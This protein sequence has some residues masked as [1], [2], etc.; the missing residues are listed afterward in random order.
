[1]VICG[2]GGNPAD[3]GITRHSHRFAPRAGFAY[4]LTES[5]VIRAGYGLTNDPTNYGASLGNRQNYPDILATAISA[6]NSFSYATTLPL[7]LPAAVQ[8]DF[9]SG[10]VA[11]PLTAGVFTL[12]NRNYVRGYVQSWNFTV[13]QRING[14]TASAGYVASRAVDP[15]AALN[16][17]WS[18]IGTGT[19]GQ[20]LS[21][22]AKRTAITNTVGI[23]GTNKYDSVQA[24]IQHSFAHGFQFNVNYTFAKAEAYST[25]VAIPAYYRLNYGATGNIAHHTVGLAGFVGSPFG[26]GKQRFGSGPEAA[27]L[28]G[29]Q[30]NATGILR[31][32]T[33][34]TATASNTTLNAVGSSQFA[35][36]VSPPHQLGDIYQWYDKTAFAAP[37]TGRFGTCGTNSLWG[38]GLVNFD[39]G[40]DRNFALLERF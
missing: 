15:I 7:G 33:P 1:M 26:K 34:F 21:V 4:R 27:V 17:N 14:W 36:C 20:I 35:D 25:Q 24:R 23:Q 28:G 38:P 39:M 6:P 8:P 37:S 16:L 13:E 2:F 9:S 10:R 5:T 3:C 19:A 18:P 29:W 22:L 40:I 32:G 11:L 31:G 12:D 30:I